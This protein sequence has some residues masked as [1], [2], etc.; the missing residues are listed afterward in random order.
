MEGAMAGLQTIVEGDREPDARL[1]E[2]AE[3]F[4]SRHEA[5]VFGGLLQSAQL[6]DGADL[7]AHFNGPDYSGYGGLDGTVVGELVWDE[8]AMLLRPDL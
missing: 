3:D 2:T 7:D 5:K 8:F 1:K 6:D 4:L